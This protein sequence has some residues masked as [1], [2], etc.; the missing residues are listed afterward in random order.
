LHAAEEEWVAGHG[1]T[2]RAMGTI[3]M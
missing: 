3:E 1:V 2:G